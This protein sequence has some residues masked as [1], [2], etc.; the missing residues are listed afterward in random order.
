MIKNNIIKN[1]FFILI[2]IASIIFIGCDNYEDSIDKYITLEYT[3]FMHLSYD[4]IADSVRSVFKLDSIEFNQKVSIGFLFHDNL[5]WVVKEGY[6]YIANNG[7]KITIWV[8]DTNNPYYV[9]YQLQ[10]GGTSTDWSFEEDSACLV[11]KSNVEKTGGS[12]TDSD[13]IVLNQWGT[14]LH[15]NRYFYELYLTQSYQDTCVNYPYFFS[16]VESDTNKVNLLLVNRWYKNL[17]DIKNT[18]SNEKIIEKAKEYFETSEKVISIM[19][20]LTIDGYYIIKDK[21]C[22]KVG[23]AIIDE[24]G[25][26][27]DLYVDIQNG[28]VIGETEVYVGK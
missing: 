21:L 6:E 9:T 12:L 24:W 28:E 5:K 13:C 20:E 8:D 26:S 22:R 16:E 4:E 2:I 23:S 25:S 15:P 1:Q 14:K 19:D 17:D 11:F 7:A 3:E 10:R 18:F 27:L